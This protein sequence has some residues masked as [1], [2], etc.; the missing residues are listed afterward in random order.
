MSISRN[1]NGTYFVAVI[2]QQ[3]RCNVL[4]R[5]LCIEGYIDMLSL[6]N[7]VHS[8]ENLFYKIHS[9]S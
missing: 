4:H 8:S 3:T 9:L 6:L 5:M 7:N 2:D 1:K